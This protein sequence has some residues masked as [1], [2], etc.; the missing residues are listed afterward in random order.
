MPKTGGQL[1]HRVR[2]LSAHSVH[3]KV[4]NAK[5]DFWQMNVHASLVPSIRSQVHTI[6]H[7]MFPHTKH[8]PTQSDFLFGSHPPL[9]FY[10]NLSRIRKGWCKEET[11][12]TPFMGAER[13]VWIELYSTFM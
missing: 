4:L 8:V 11:H 7:F 2:L 3:V 1:Y 9:T 10:C 12:T 6:H 13:R 5:L